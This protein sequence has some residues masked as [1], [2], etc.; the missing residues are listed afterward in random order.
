MKRYVKIYILFIRLNYRR[1]SLHMGNFMTGLFGNVAWGIFSILAIYILSARSTSIFGWSREELF[2][3]AGTYNIL[4]GGS[5]RMLFA[6]NFENMINLIRL[7]GLDGVLLKPLNSQFG[8]STGHLSIYSMARIVLSVI[9]VFIVMSIAGIEIGII[10]I[11]SFLIFGFFGLIAL[12]AFWFIIM[13]FIIWFPDLYNI[14]EIPYSTD[15]LARYPPQIL[16]AMKMFIFLF[17]FPV[18]LVV[19]T[20]TKALIDKLTLFDA[21]LLIAV[22]LGLLFVSSKFWK[23]SLRNYTSASS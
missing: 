5:F 8:V 2:V 13:S 3:L 20:P 22:A 15:N 18:S 21:G 1:A 7:G 9:Y 16:W 12:Y 10:N 6:R 19:S 11:V 17:A 14:D 4:V 23:F